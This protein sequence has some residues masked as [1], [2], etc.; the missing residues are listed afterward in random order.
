MS[1]SVSSAEVSKSFG[2][3]SRRALQSP[4]TITHHG[5]DSL[6]L[7]SHAEYQRLKSRDR[8]ALTLDAFTA[9][10]RAAIAAS[11]PP[12]EAADF[13]AEVLAR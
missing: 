13:D 12:A 11:R 7:M 6:V 5:H 2:R 8:E 3:A 10:D 1:Q 9:E 4:L